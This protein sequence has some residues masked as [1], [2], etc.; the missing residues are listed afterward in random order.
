VVL[1]DACGIEPPLCGYLA[2]INPHYY[3]PPLQTAADAL[4]ALRPKCFALL[5]FP[6]GRCSGYPATQLAPRS[7]LLHPRTPS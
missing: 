7:Q 2:A 1:V 6:S 4:P 3:P 5:P